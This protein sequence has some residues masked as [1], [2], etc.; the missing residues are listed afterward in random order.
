MT[1]NDIYTKFMIE[2][3][4]ANVTSSYPALTKYEVA[5]LLDRAYLLLIARKLTGNNTRRVPFEY[6]TKAIEDLRPLIDTESLNYVNAGSVKNEH[7]YRLPSKMLYYLQSIAK[8]PGD[9][10]QRENVITTNHKLAEKFKAT[11]TNMPWITEPV[12]YLEGNNVHIFIDPYKH[13]GHPDLITT[14]IKIP[15]KFVESLKKVED[16]PEDPKDPDYGTPWSVYTQDV[17]TQIKNKISNSA[18]F[19]VYCTKGD[20]KCKCK[21]SIINGSDVIRIDKSQYNN[22]TYTLGVYILKTGSADIRFTCE[23]DTS[24]YKDV[25]ITV[26]YLST[27]DPDVPTDPNIPTNPDDSTNPKDPITSPPS[28]TFISCIYNIRGNIIQSTFKVNKNNFTDPILY[29]IVVYDKNKTVLRSSQIKP[30]EISQY[31]QNVT[32]GIQY[33][34]GAKS[35]VIKLYYENNIN[36]VT[37]QEMDIFNVPTEIET[38]T[39]E[40]HDVVDLGLPS[41]T[42]W[43]TCNIGAQS[44]ADLG[45]YIAFGE[46]EPKEQ[47]SI[48]NYSYANTSLSNIANSSGQLVENCDAAHKRWKGYFRMPTKED[49]EELI[50]NCSIQFVQMTNSYGNNVYG[51]RYTSNINGE[52][53]FLPCGG[54]KVTSSSSNITSTYSEDVAYYWTSSIN[55]DYQA[56]AFV[57][58]PTDDYPAPND[59]TQSYSI[60]QMQ[61]LHGRSGLLIRPVYPK[62]TGNPVLSP[63]LELDNNG[64]TGRLDSFT[65]NNNSLG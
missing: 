35:V 38:Q 26:T 37:S 41:G 42:Q 56:W 65:L 52:S 4:K 45:D 49:C 1:H 5:T 3:D 24:V 34:A 55:G 22:N 19:Q 13:K 31:G 21:I 58:S 48:N 2:Y 14:F 62:E 15:A 47:Y 25:H 53:I 28:I 6:D 54:Y 64:T 16:G 18:F 23:E 27:T 7:K 11:N 63:S 20:Q 12:S 17:P 61:S 8:Y 59:N 44:I 29:N 46:S 51:V 10:Y 9:D 60:T 36:F 50:Q 33:D 57:S 39:P 43:A 30:F 32:E 40:D